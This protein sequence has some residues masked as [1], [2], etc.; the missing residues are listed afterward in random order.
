MK[1]IL[2]VIVGPTGIG[3]TGTAIVLADHFQT[4][5]ISA[6]SRQ[7]YREMEMGTAV[8]SKEEQ[9]KV[10]HHFLQ[11]RSIHDYYNASMFEMEVLDLLENLFRKKDI[12]L[13]VGGS[14]LYVDAVCKGIDDIP[15][16][17]PEVRKSLSDQYTTEGIESLRRQLKILD[18]VYYEKVDL[19][20]HKR[21]LKA[22]EI[23]L[24]TGR[25]YSSFLTRETK[26]RN[27][28][29]LKIGLNRDRKELYEII[30]QRVDDMIRSGLVEEAK[31]LLPYREINPLNTVGYKE[32]FKHFEGKYTLEEAISLIKRNSRRYAKRQ[33]SWFSRDKEIR[34][35]HP[36]DRE[37]IMQFIS[38][39]IK[40]YDDFESSY[41]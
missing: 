8:P 4:D 32:L 16:I 17:D 11:T 37:E 6:D 5:I 18:P 9:E 14:G 13:L 33:I 36:D 28:Q 41:D 26:E 1:K 12:V 15:S 3:K 7:I 21:I 22:L 29:I 25:P 24:M 31:K 20:N 39:A 23:S 35:F 40:S 38:K 30:D 34:W 2:V 27:F 10:K 19:K